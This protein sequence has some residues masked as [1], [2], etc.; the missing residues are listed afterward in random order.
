[1]ALFKASALVACRCHH[2][3]LPVLVDCFGDPLGVRIPSDSLR[4]W[5]SEDNL[6]EFA[7][8]IFT[9]PVR[10]QDSQGPALCLARSSAVD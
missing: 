9:N 10:I 1:M 7:H 8:G 6:K 4:E 3:Y 5:I 2:S